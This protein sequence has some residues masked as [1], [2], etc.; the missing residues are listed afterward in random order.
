M[1]FAY[2]CYPD[3]IYLWNFPNNGRSQSFYR[4]IQYLLNLVLM[5]WMYLT[6]II[7]P[8]EMVPD[9]LRFVFSFNPMAVLI[10]AY[11]QVILGMA[12]PKFS[13]LSIALVISLL[14]CLI[15]NYIFKKLEG[16]FADVV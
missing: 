11:R 5:L 13:S 4:D 3:A 15:G 8:V 1:D 2:F 16:S 6:P 9:R 14:F 10:N 12:N 7:Y